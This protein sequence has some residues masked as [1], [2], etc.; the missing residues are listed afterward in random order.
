M[1]YYY[2]ISRNEFEI[3]LNY[4]RYS[5]PGQLS[6]PEIIPFT[7]YEKLMFKNMFNTSS[8]SI[9]F[10]PDTIEID[11]TRLCAKYINFGCVIYK[12][13]DEWYAVDI[14][15]T[16]YDPKYNVKVNLNTYY[17]CDQ[18]DG[19]LEFA[20]QILDDPDILFNK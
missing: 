6:I 4:T 15:K 16:H 7:E 5:R 19:L 3:L 2:M 9:K 13:Q 8:Y 20:K 11:Q 10:Y 17:K 18:L 12:V 1:K 14:D